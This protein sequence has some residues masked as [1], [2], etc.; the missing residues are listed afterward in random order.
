MGFSFNL[1]R[2]KSSFKRLWQ[3]LECQSEEVL[4]VIEPDCLDSLIFGQHHIGTQDYFVPIHGQCHTILLPG[5]PHYHFLERWLDEPFSE[6]A[7]TKYLK[8]SWG[9]RYG[10]ERNTPEQR[11][12]QIQKYLELY[13]DTASRVEAQ[14]PAFTKPVEVCPRPD[15]RL[16]IIDGN[17]RSSIALKLGL[18]L[19]VRMI[20]PGVYLRQTSLIPDEFYGSKRMDMPYQS[21]FHGEQELVQGR[22]PDLLDRMALIEPRD[23]EGK[24]VLDLACN[25]GANSF[26]AAYRG[27]KQ[28]V[29]IDYS[30]RIISAALRLNAYFAMPCEFLVADLNTCLTGLP[31]FD[32][33]FCFSLTKHLSN[34]DGLKATILHSTRGV[35]YFEGHADSNREDYSFIL[36]P[37]YFSSIELIGY[38]RNG[39]HTDRSTRPFFRCER[40]LEQ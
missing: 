26:L 40:A 7:Y 39:I 2:I 3:G 32:T 19:Q 20:E 18:N 13:K 12:A 1:T 23:L 31:R 36:N 33:V 38:N 8:H 29:G 9:Y 21:I 11:Q 37:S 25:I 24:T 14:Q 5:F 30:P 34:L 17:H 28:V 16:I 35:L 22:R 6:H 4:R 15:G 27:A 10:P